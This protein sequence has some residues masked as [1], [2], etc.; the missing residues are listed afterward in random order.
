MHPLHPSHHLMFTTMR[1]SR[2]LLLSGSLLA[3]AACGG[4]A[5]T[6]AGDTTT[7]AQGSASA[8]GAGAAPTGELTPDAGGKI[9]TVQMETDD[10]GNNKFDPAD[11]DA[12]KGDV[13]RYTLKAGV[14]NVHFLADSN[15]GK[16]G[17]P[18][19]TQMLQLPGQTVDVKVDWAPGTYYY[20]C[21]PHALLGMKG[22]VRVQ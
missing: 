3:L 10:A 4:N 18:A 5:D 21:D 12:K 22:H 1:S 15:A 11:F 7:P 20:Q 8:S 6:G 9:I 14:H 17:L 19:A 2:L 16:T 13:I